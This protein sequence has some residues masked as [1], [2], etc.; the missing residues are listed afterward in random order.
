[1]LGINTLPTVGTNETDFR[2]KCNCTVKQRMYKE[3]KSLF[4]NKEKNGKQLDPA[5]EGWRARARKDFHPARGIGYRPGYAVQHVWEASVGS[6]R[7]AGGCAA[8]ATPE[9]IRKSVSEA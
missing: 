8:I 2:G 9:G 3:D 6:G 5:Q 1:M 4:S 7:A